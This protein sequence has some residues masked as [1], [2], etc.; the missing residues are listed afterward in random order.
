MDNLKLKK[1]I[2]SFLFLCVCWVI[3]ICLPIK[4]ASRIF[5]DGSLFILYFL[6]IPFIFSF[7]IYKFFVIKETAF[8]IHFIL[9]GI[10][11]PIII[12]YVYLFIEFQKGFNLSL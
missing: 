3:F 10:V 9:I 5:W 2:Y 8:K 4:Y 7:L 6:I 12:L 11:V 1:I